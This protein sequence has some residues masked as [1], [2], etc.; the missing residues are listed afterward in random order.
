MFTIC[1]YQS[2]F[3]FSAF[4]ELDFKHFAR[5]T[6]NKMIAHNPCDRIK[7]PD[8]LKMLETN[9]FQNTKDSLRKDLTTDSASS[10]AKDNDAFLVMNEEH[11]LLK[12]VKVKL[13]NFEVEFDLRFYLPF[14]L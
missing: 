9:E 7:L 12:N 11:H 10:L 8:V 6:I 4:I 13:R 1:S 5:S 3:L 14:D 2:R